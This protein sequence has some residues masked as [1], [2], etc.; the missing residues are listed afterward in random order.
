M[1][2]FSLLLVLS[3]AA[4]SL[5][6]TCSGSKQCQCLFSD[7]SHCCLYGQVRDLIWLDMTELTQSLECSDRRHLRLYHALLR[8]QPATSVGRRYSGQVQ[9][10]RFICLCFSYYCPG[11]HTLLQQ[12]LDIERTMVLLVSGLEIPPGLGSNLGS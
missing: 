2:G 6:A 1:K 8:C 11:S 9:C 12:R 10:R 3:T 4:M 5:A 7:G